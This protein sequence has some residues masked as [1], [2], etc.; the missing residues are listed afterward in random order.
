ML[1]LLFFL[2]LVYLVYRLMRAIATRWR[3]SERIERDVSRLQSGDDDDASAATSE[4]VDTSGGPL[5]PQHRRR[6]LRD[7]RLLPKKK[8]SVFDGKRPRVMDKAEAGRLFSATLRTR[9]RHVRD[10]LADEAQLARYGLPLWRSEAELA[11]AL[12]IGEKLLRHYSIHRQ[13]ERVAHYVTFAIPK[14][15]GGERLILAPKRKLKAIQ[16]QLNAM[17]VARLPVSEHAHGFRPGRSIATNAQPHAGK[18]VVLKL[19]I[20]DF[21]PSLHVGRVRGLL[22]ALGYGYPVATALAVLMTESVRQPVTIEGTTYL[23]PVGS[24]HAVQG[25][26]TSP[27]LA[28]ALT[29]KLDRRL[30]GL[31]RA[32]GFAYTRYADDLAFSG[33]SAETARRLIKRAESIVRAEGF[34]INRDKTALMTQARNQRV[35]GVT[36]NAQPGWSRRQRRL[37]RAQLHQAGLRHAEDHAENAPLWR[38]LRGTL[39]FVR[40]LNRRQAEVLERFVRPAGRS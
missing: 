17:L 38:R 22:I 35:A 8:R 24:R 40:M 26:P 28:N 33:D 19:D 4:V 36:V 32:H 34:R 31:A 10:L 18:R 29:L 37:L 12:G 15:S 27:G 6:A 14:R 11:K 5:K 16:R 13:K 21:F 39:A 9:D 2:A 20:Q 25:A 23:V 3:G 7:P 1:R 30:A